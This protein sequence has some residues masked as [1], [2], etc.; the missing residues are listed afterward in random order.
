ME[1]RKISSLNLQLQ[2]AF[3]ERYLLVGYHYDVPLAFYDVSDDLIRVFKENTTE[4]YWFALLKFSDDTLEP[5]QVY[6]HPFDKTIIIL[7]PQKEYDFYVEITQNGAVLFHLWQFEPNWLPFRTKPSFDRTQNSV[8]FM[9]TKTLL[10][11]T[12]HYDIELYK[13]YSLSKKCC[14]RAFELYTRGLPLPNSLCN[15]PKDE[16]A[17]ACLAKKAIYDFLSKIGYTT[18]SD[19]KQKLVKLKRLNKLIT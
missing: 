11:I 9:L 3:D 18:Y 4:K 17:L 1:V 5:H 19:F 16:L 10:E 2:K 15:T 13:L 8:E 12:A 6:I 7:D 14:P